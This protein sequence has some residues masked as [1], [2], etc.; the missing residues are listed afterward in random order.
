MQYAWLTWSL[1]LLGIWVV[2]YATLDSKEK[3]REMLIVSLW[4]SL[5]GFTEPIFVPEYWAPPS[6]F[7]LALTTGFDIESI[8]FSFAIGG[9]ASVIYE[10][11][12][13]SR[14]EQ[15]S[16]QAR[17]DPRHR[18]HAWALL[19]APIAFSILSF[20]TN[21]NP[22]Y[23]ASIALFIGGIFSLYCRPDLWRKMFVS[24]FIFLVLY[25]LYFMTLIAL[26]PGYVERVWNLAAVSGNL[27]IGVPV[28][29]LLFALSFGFI[30][31]SIYEH[32]TWRKINM[33]AHE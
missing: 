12:F 33:S 26:Y 21:L 2:I 17:H 18:F 13:T 22:I 27:I 5:L 23:A 1:I 20:T 28:E 7:N 14:H 16:P 32:F 9:G 29:E 11:I 4:T 31:S 24:A 30:W 6:L 8:I 10:R 15:M 3:K 19:S 25:F